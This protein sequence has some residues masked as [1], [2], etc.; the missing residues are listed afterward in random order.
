M[1]TNERPWYEA[2]FESGDYTRFWLGGEGAPRIP[3]ERT[4]REVDFA[5]S[6]LGLQPGQHVLD[7][8]CGYGRHS[9]ELARRGYRVTGVDLSQ[10][11]LG[12][13]RR[14]AAEAGID[15]EWV[16]A[17]MRELPDDLSGQ[18]DAVVNMFTAFGYFEDEA[19]DQ[20]VLEGVAR[21]LRPGGKLLI[22][23]I[24]RE[25]TMRR[26]RFKDWEAFDDGAL[27]LHERK[28]DMVTSI[29]TDEMTIVEADGSR[30]N[31]SIAVR[32]YTL[33]ELIA[34]LSRAGLTFHQ[35]WGDFDGSDYGIDSRRMIVMAE[36]AE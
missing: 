14:A 34:M 25:G 36:K 9:I 16:E 29:Q 22:D 32:W 2:L 10:A 28:F 4:Q 18:I 21:V 33:T 3:A 19:E 26:F 23:F 20:R 1:E 8:C 12:M 7:L 27:V 17:D 6:V 31:G 13:A 24:N 5:V 35:A 30:H 15:V 11:Q